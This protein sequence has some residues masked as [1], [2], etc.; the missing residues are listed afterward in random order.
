MCFFTTQWKAGIAIISWKMKTMFGWI[1]E[2]A[3]DAVSD[4]SSA[5]KNMK[6]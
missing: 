3:P 2:S 6:T 4:S 1:V 5:A